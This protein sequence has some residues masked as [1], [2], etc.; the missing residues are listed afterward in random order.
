MNI[1]VFTSNQ[2]RHM[3]LLERLCGVADTV[4][5]IMECGTLFPGH[6]EGFFHKS[7][8]MQRYFREVQRAE[9]EVFGRPRLARAGL[10][11]LPMARGDLG[12][13]DMQ[14]FGPALDADLFVVFGASYIK[15]ALAN[16]LLA[17]HALNIH[18]GISPAYRG[19][20]C[21]FW[22][23]YDG[24]PELV[25]GTVHLL[26]RGLDSGDILFHCLPPAR[27]I[28]PFTLGMMAVES[29]IEGLAWHVAEGTLT[30]LAPVAQDKARELRYSR[31][32]E[33]TDEVAQAYLKHLPTP[34]TIGTA[35]A[36]RDLS[37]L[38]RP[39]VAG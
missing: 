30:G 10:R 19:S 23:L 9:T 16:H 18:M 1:T 3:A 31:G 8:V 38:V 33:F 4:N 24:H 36:D 35:L 29:A 14:A 22:A 15:G 2:P 37:G 13:M 28:D 5:A 20:S 32:A 26:S 6:V 11:V 12:H 7:E 34:E 25:G 21:N 17:R 39:F 27:S